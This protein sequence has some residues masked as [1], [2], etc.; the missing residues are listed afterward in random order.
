MDIAAWIAL[1][2]TTV[3]LLMIMS[4]VFFH[5]WIAGER[6]LGIVGWAVLL[7]AMPA[8]LMIW[9]AWAL[10]P[11]TA[12]DQRPPL[13]FVLVVCGSLLAVASFVAGIEVFRLLKIVAMT[14]NKTNLLV[15]VANRLNDVEDY[16]RILHF[17]LT[18]DYQPPLPA[19]TERALRERGVLPAEPPPAE[20]ARPAVVHPGSTEIVYADPPDAV[21]ATPPAPVSERRP[22]I[23]DAADAASGE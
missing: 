4:R 3:L 17:N 5:D 21:P 2:F 18:A 9:L 14:D 12:A 7:G 13:E 16:L 22:A 20:P 15:T 11:A 23:G 10:N 8:T 6:V 1:V 19:D